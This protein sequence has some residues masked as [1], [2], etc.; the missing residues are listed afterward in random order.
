VRG[1]VALTVDIEAFEA[2][3]SRVD[4]AE[5]A[6]VERVVEAD[7]VIADARPERVVGGGHRIVVGALC[8][9]RDRGADQA[10]SEQAACSARRG[11]ADRQGQASR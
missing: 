11:N 9:G 1:E 8:G 6:N 3:I 5:A 4:R 10:E 2:D 7:P